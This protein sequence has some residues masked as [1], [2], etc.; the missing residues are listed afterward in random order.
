MKAISRCPSYVPPNQFNRITLAMSPPA[1]APLDPSTD[2]MKE[3]TELD[4]KPGAHFVG[5]LA[6]VSRSAMVQVAEE[7]AA[8]DDNDGGVSGGRIGDRGLLGLVV[9]KRLVAAR[10]LNGYSQIEAATAVGYG[11]PAQLSLWEAG[12]RNPPLAALV[13]Y[14]DV[15]GVS[16]DYIVGRS[17]DAE[18]NVRLVRQNA[19]MRAVRSTLTAAV[20]RIVDAFDSDES[21]TGLNVGIVL[22][23]VVAAQ[24]VTAVYGDFIQPYRT[25]RGNTGERLASAV[26]RLEGAALKVG[27]ALRRHDDED[28][29]LK[30]QLAEI[31][32]NDPD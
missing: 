18:R 13:Q 16:L 14:A 4:V 7:E 12:K 11:T 1:V 17:E 32:A 10:L 2:P 26:I 19:C 15:M 27:V 8:A 29:A 3:S 21:I 5:L 6:P 23:L 22:E 20:E 28:A 9:A 25:G 30:R 31:A 24:A